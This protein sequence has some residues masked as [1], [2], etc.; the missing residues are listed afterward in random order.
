MTKKKKT[1]ASPAKVGDCAVKIEDLTVGDVICSP[2]FQSRMQKACD[3]LKASRE[4]A[5]RNARMN[6]S[7]LKAHPIDDFINAGSF[8]APCM[9]KHFQEVLNKESSLSVRLRNFVYEFGMSVYRDEVKGYIKR[10]KDAQE[11][12]RKIIADKKQ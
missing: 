1:V 5:R 4:A 3:N 9:A 6:G 2:G 11:R 12:V 7:R 10:D 8:N